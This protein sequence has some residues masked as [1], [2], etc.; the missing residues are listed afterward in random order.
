METS[1]RKVSF[2]R[3]QPDDEGPIEEAAAI[4]RAGGLVAFAT[5][6]VYGLGADATEAHAVGRIF[7][8]KGRPSHNPLIVHASDMDMA[9]SCVGDWTDE[10][11]ELAQRYWPGPLTLVLPRS[12]I[13]ADLVTAGGSTV[14]VRIPALRVARS[15]IARVGR[16]IAAPSANRSN[17]IS[18]TT[19]QHVQSDLDGRIEMILDSGPCRVGLESTVLDLSSS[20]PR[21]LRP[22]P[23]TAMEI[24]RALGLVLDRTPSPENPTSPASPGQQPVHYAPTTRA[25]WVEPDHLA[26]VTLTGPTALL[27]FEKFVPPDPSPFQRSMAY[28]TPDEAARDLYRLLHEW[29]EEGFSQI[30]VVPPPDRD[31]WRAIRD[32]LGRATVKLLP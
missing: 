15:L 18:P 30:V 19:A 1:I 31:A 16:P 10:A 28:R 6:T 23:I 25:Y 21:I 17:R 3:T 8:A 4:L 2:D 24:E 7:E 20:S 14:G 11:E 29:D 9:R 5:E 27:T 13:I 32:R 26:G 12:P 22:G